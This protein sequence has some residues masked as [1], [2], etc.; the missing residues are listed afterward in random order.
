MANFNYDID[1]KEI[2]A[3][4]LRVLDKYGITEPVV[5]VVEIANG[6]G[7]KIKEVEM[8]EEY[9]NVAG[10]YD[11]KE[12][13]IFIAV[14]DTPQRKLFSVAHELGHIFLNHQNATVLYRITREDTNYS[15]EEREANSFAAHL[16]MPEY[17]I[18]EY[19]DKYDLRRSDY[20]IM[21]KMFGV[22]EKS[23]RHTL[24]FLR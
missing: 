9:K 1:Q 12:K 10:F 3:R 18:N 11:K 7:I 17:M 15:K 19:M 13:T 22:P 14:N 2:E 20:K 5:D 21:A 8:P 4:A 23:M 6:E 24:E 16:L